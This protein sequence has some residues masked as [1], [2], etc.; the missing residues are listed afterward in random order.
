[1]KYCLQIECYRRSSSRECLLARFERLERKDWH[2]RVCFA[3]CSCWFLEVFWFLILLDRSK[4]L[5]ADY[6]QFNS[7]PISV[8]DCSQSE[9]YR[10]FIFDL[11]LVAR[12]DR[13]FNHYRADSGIA[14]VLLA[15]LVV[16]W[17]LLRSYI[18]QF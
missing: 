10:H 2:D 18:L 1:M 7:W 16:L 13:Y 15:A 4:V 12:I 6:L 14:L 8:K 3:C 9:F 11:L 17:F 5:S